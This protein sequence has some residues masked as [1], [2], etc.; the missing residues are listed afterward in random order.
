MKTAA[1]LLTLV[2]LVGAAPAAAQQL[3]RLFL[4]PEERAVLDARRAAR[5][6]DRPQTV[7]VESPTTRIDG[8]VLRSG[9]HST[10]WIDGRAVR[11]GV[12]TEGIRVQPAP[13]APGQVVVEFGDQ[14]RPIDLKIGQSVER[15]TGAVRGLLGDRGRIQ[16]K[17]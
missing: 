7:V 12:P 14:S 6:P 1:G 11:E 17:K 3:E 13:S 10:L 4:T 15:D 9:G 8:Q 5:V 2:V 16:I